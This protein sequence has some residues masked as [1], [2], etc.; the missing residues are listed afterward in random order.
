MALVITRRQ[1]CNRHNVWNVK[2]SVQRLQQQKSSSIV[3]YLFPRWPALTAGV[4]Q[5]SEPAPIFCCGTFNQDSSTV[6][7]INLL[8]L[9]KSFFSVPCFFLYSVHTCQ[10]YFCPQNALECLNIETYQCNEVLTQQGGTWI[11]PSKFQVTKQH[12][13][14]QFQNW[15]VEVLLCLH[16]NCL[17]QLT[18]FKDWKGTQHLFLL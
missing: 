4:F 5:G 13:K 1:A 14:R 8:S 2:L 3:L 18:Q 11:R 15:K 7:Q 6:K 10:M 9:F 17:I 12:T 16:L